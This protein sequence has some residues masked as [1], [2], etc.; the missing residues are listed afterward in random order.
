LEEEDKWTQYKEDGTFLIE[1]SDFLNIFT[2]IIFNRNIKKSFNSMAFK[3]IWNLLT[4][5]LPS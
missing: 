5:G 2:D 3:G 4:P 1:W